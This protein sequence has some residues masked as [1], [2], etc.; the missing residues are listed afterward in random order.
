MEMQRIKGK[1]GSKLIESEA[2]CKLSTWQEIESTQLKN[3]LGHVPME[4]P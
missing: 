3:V 1:S 4:A 2:A